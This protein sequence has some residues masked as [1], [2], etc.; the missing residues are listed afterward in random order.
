MNAMSSMKSGV[1]VLKYT[2]H[3]ISVAALVMI[4][5]IAGSAA[6]A[7]AWTIRP[8]VAGVTPL[9]GAT[10][11]AL[12]STIVVTFNEPMKC[13]TLNTKTFKLLAPHK[14]PVAGA[15]TCSNGTSIFT[16]TFTPSEN[17]ATHTTYTAKLTDKVKALNHKIL[18]NGFTG[19]FTTGP[20]V[21]PTSTPTATSTATPTPTATSTATATASATPTHTATATATATRT[22]TATP[23][24]T[25]T[26]TATSTPTSTATSTATPTA[27]ATASRTATA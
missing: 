19:T 15:V 18:E 2:I 1:M 6:V 16:A 20:C 4:A 23:T 9:G 25:D 12:D 13:Q 10:C 21:L 17:L 26:A 14:V 27:T 11:M 22:A 8:K 3:R 5:C 7:S 24:S